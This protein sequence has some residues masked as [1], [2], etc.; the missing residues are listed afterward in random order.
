[1]ARL[2]RNRSASR[3][4]VRRN[5]KQKSIFG[6]LTRTASVSQVATGADRCVRRPVP[7]RLASNSVARHHGAAPVEVVVDAAAHDHA[8]VT[9]V[10]Q[11][12]IVDRVAIGPEIE[13]QGFGLD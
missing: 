13:V 1:M 3:K 12:G 4:S 6:A 5:L 8:A 7:G 11:E 10:D 2:E 9:G